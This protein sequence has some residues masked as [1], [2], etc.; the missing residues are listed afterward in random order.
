MKW[1]NARNLVFILVLVGLMALGSLGL[2]TAMEWEFSW[3]RLAF[4]VTTGLVIAFYVSNRN[5]NKGLD[6]QQG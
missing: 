6:T 1:L 2:S 5:R 4:S 3:A